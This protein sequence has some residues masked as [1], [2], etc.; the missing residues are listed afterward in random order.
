MKVNVFTDRFGN[1]LFSRQHFPQISKMSELVI[2]LSHFTT[3]RNNAFQILVELAKSPINLTSKLIM[4][5][6]RSAHDIGFA[7]T[8]LVSLNEM[9]MFPM[10]I[11]KQ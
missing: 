6:P 11:W 3:V 2:Y 9:T 4:K 7:R 1:D 10:Q 5:I 8:A